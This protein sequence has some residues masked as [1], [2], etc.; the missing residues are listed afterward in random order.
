V[1][2]HQ[3]GLGFAAFH[4]PEQGG[5]ERALGIEPNPVIAKTAL[6]RRQAIPKKAFG[7]RIFMLMD[8]VAAEVVERNGNIA[9]SGTQ[10]GPTDLQYLWEKRL[11][12]LWKCALSVG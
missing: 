4:L 2:L 3:P 11:G 1:A 12:A 9:M 8:Q 7:L 6:A 5:S 10:L